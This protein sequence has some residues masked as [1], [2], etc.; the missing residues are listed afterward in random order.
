MNNLKFANCIY[1]K[2]CLNF[3]LTL[4]FVMRVVLSKLNRF[5]GKQNV[6]QQKQPHFYSC[7]LNSIILE[8][9][10]L[11]KLWVMPWCLSVTTKPDKSYIFYLTWLFLWKNSTWCDMFKITKSVLVYFIRLIE[12]NLGWGDKETAEKYCKLICSGCVAVPNKGGNTFPDFL[13]SIKFYL[14]CLR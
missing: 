2:T 13:M 11:R 12:W 7:F 1:H 5:K 6:C 10:K 14:M 8:P 4:F 9:S 3:E